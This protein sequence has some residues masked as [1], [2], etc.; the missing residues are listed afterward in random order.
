MSD[1][2]PSRTE[3]NLALVRTFFACFAAGDLDTLRKEV[4]AP[5]VVWHVPGR[6]PLSGTHRG[7]DQMLAFFAQLGSSGFQ[8]EVQFL[9]ADDERVVDVHRGWSGRK[10]GSDIDLD[11]VLVY[12]IEN[13]RITEAR[14]FVSDQAAADTFFLNAHPLAPLP[15]RLAAV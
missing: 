6:H 5:D 1:S 8:A 2:Q 11:W 13:G 10:D 3:A 7:V 9:Q 14:N 4:L 12:R 15:D